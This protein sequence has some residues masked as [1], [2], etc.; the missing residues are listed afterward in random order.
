MPHTSFYPLS[1][2]AHPEHTFSEDQNREKKIQ[3]CKKKKKYQRAKKEVSHG[4][5]EEMKEN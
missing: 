1:V 5:K 2:T 3:M 4:K